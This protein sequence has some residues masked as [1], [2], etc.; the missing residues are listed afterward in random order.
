[1]VQNT[2]TRIAAPSDADVRLSGAR[3][4]PQTAGWLAA[5]KNSTAHGSENEVDTDE[6]VSTLEK[7][8][9]SPNTPATARITGIRTLNQVTP[10]APT[11]DLFT[12]RDELRPRRNSWATRLR[13]RAGPVAASN[14]RS[15]FPGHCESRRLLS[16]DFSTSSAASAWPAPSL[17]PAPHTKE[18]SAS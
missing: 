18:A 3:S 11:D 8:I 4:D 7:I 14:R 16:R 15:R 10:E 1:V 13:L 9:R 2:P 17:T 12:D 6:M 5:R